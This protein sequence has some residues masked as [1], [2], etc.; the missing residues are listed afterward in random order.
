MAT[1]FTKRTNSLT[2]ENNSA[3]KLISG[4]LKGK[5]PEKLDWKKVKSDHLISKY[6]FSE[7]QQHVILS[8]RSESKDLL[9]SR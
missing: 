2:K 3:V 4:M 8:E 9:N 6:R 7:L 5:T 1:K